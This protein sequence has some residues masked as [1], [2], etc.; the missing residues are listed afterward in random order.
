MKDH[1]HADGSKPAADSAKE[2]PAM[3]AT[4]AG[5]IARRPVPVLNKEGQPVF[6]RDG[7]P[8]VDLKPIPAAEIFAF[9]DHGDFVRVVTV[10]G[11]KFEG[12]K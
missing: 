1:D 6:D 9:R 2:T 12:T 3:T 7:T 8:K 4:E 5:R 10:D 11:Q